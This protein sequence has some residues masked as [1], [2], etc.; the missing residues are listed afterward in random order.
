[1]LKSVKIE[2]KRSSFWIH[3]YEM[4]IGRDAI[5]STSFPLFKSIANVYDTKYRIYRSTLDLYDKRNKIL[6]IPAGYGLD[7][8]IKNLNNS[9]HEVQYSFEDNSNYYID[10]NLIPNR[11][12]MKKGYEPRDRIQ[13]NAITFLTNSLQDK[14][15]EAKG[16]QLYLSLDTGMGKTFCAIYSIIK[17]RLPVIIISFNLSEQWKEKI[18]EYTTARDDDICMIR[19]TDSVKKILTSNKKYSFYIASVSTLRKFSDYYKN[20][21]LI[22]EKMG[23]ALK[24]FDEAHNQYKA[25]ASIDVNSDIRF[26]FYLT[27][28]PGRSDYLDDRVYQ[29]LFRYVPMHG[30]YTHTFKNHYK[31]KYIK[32]NTFPKQIDRRKCSTSKGFNANNYFKYIL[33][34]EEKSLGMLGMIKY[35][36]DKILVPFPTHRVLVFV[37][38]LEYMDFAYNFLTKNYQLSYSVGQYN[39]NVK[40]LK[41]R[42]KMLDR[43]LIITTIA[44]ASTGKDIP[45]L[46]GILS[47]TPFSSQIICRQLLGRLRELQDGGDSYFFDFTDLGFT[48]QVKQS[49]ARANVL[50]QR[51]K[52][53][54]EKII[55]LNDMIL[56]LKDGIKYSQYD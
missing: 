36:A 1:M 17:L 14:P 27:A 3:G 42:E 45:Y 11:I 55:N 47:L 33:E 32:F 8:I 51:A 50:N 46:K 28:T 29:N 20:F 52:S 56:Y 7:D 31:I 16:P 6:K 44:A 40:N 2:I 5:S 54:E 35:F 39:S 30:V 41:E 24:I 22:F 48:G 25:N 49:F 53:I 34:N 10:Y 13:E 37:P 12:Q 21:N 9:Y 15:E 23:V 4:P 19:G 18:K 26:T 38:S 43:N